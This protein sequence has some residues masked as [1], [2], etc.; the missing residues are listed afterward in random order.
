MSALASTASCG[1]RREVGK[2]P[3]ATIHLARFRA[4]VDRFSDARDAVRGAVAHR[5]VSRDGAA[6]RR[7]SGFAARWP[8]HPST[9]RWRPTARRRRFAAPDGRLADHRG[10][11]K[12]V[13]RRAMAARRR[14]RP[15]RPPRRSGKTP[16]TSSAASAHLPDGRSL[17]P[18]VRQARLRRRLRPRRYHR[19]AAVRA[20][21]LRRQPR[22]RPRRA[23][24]RPA[25]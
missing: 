7:A 18:R 24:G 5:A 20:D 4:L 15:R 6:A 14:R 19:D 22:H 10:A 17:S 1:R 11:P 16:A 9:S 25:P 3:G 23:E 13:R 8:D 21:R 2:L 12:P